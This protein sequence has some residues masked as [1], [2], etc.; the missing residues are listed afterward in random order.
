MTKSRFKGVAGLALIAAAGLA[1]VL[2]GC[3]SPQAKQAASVQPAAATPSTTSVAGNVTGNVGKP[4]IV[5]LRRMNEGQY[6]QSVADIFGSDIDVVGRFEPDARRD[7]LLAVGSVELS[8][9][10]G[11]IEQYISMARSIAD[12]VF[13]DKRRAKFETCKPADE[14]AA[15]AACAAT[16]IKTQGEKLFRR[17]LTEAEVKSRVDL[18]GEGAAKLGSYTTGMKLALVSL[19]TS[20]EFLFRVETAEADPAAPGRLRLDGY[21]KAARLSYL[22]WNTTPDAELL[23]VAASGEIHTAAGLKKQVDRLGAS[24]RLEQGVRALFRDMMQFS[25][26]E[27]TTKDG[28]AYPKYSFAIAEAAQEQTLRTIVDV[29]LTKNG[30]YRDIFTTPTTFMNRPL[31][32]VYDVPFLTNSDWQTYTYPADAD[33]AGVVTQVAFMSMFSHP[34]RTSPTKRGVALHEVFLCQE[35]PLPADNVDFTLINDTA[36]ATLKTVRQRLEVHRTNVACA[37][38]HNLVDPLGVALEKFDGIGQ[39]REIENGVRIDDSSQLDGTPFN[40]A[41]GLGK[42]M[43]ANEQAPK[44][45]VR[46]VFAYGAGRLPE[47]SNEW[48]LVSAQYKAFETSGYKLRPLM[49]EIATSPD[50]YTVVFP[51]APKVVDAKSADAGDQKSGQTG[52]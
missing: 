44:C 15:D 18:A 5:A 1:A 7:G 17:P 51:K 12:Q 24:P 14:K 33:Q 23:Q 42:V 6:R 52:G 36:N 35:M 30:D 2:V 39:R 49:N 48:G 26:F 31:A 11:G 41:K 32:S 50:F 22:Y 46:N 38:C 25:R 9:T 37:G 27:N 43:H 13:D 16:F 20:P 10:S 4:G 19:L 8:I 21:T 28:A 29:T 45:L 34:G 40:G 3:A 47:A